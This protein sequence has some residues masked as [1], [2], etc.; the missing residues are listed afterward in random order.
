MCSRTSALLFVP[1]I[2]PSSNSSAGWQSNACS[3]RRSFQRSAVLPTPTGVHPRP[4]TPRSWSQRNPSRSRNATSDSRQNCPGRTTGSR[5]SGR[6]TM[7]APWRRIELGLRW[8]P[9]VLHDNSITDD[10]AG[11][12]ADVGL[13]KRMR[14]IRPGRGEVGSPLRPRSRSFPRNGERHLPT[15]MRVAPECREVNRVRRD[16]PASPRQRRRQ[17]IGWR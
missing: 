2:L 9:V 16:I 3:T 17:P 8:G 12:V 11:V 13:M 1:F 6:S 15:S 7:G 5:H 4:E 14:D 10:F